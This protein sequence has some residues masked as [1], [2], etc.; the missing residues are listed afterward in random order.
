MSCCVTLFTCFWEF[1]EY[2]ALLKSSTNQF[3]LKQINQI[4]SFSLRMR[5]TYKLVCTSKLILIW[6][7]FLMTQTLRRTF[8]IHGLVH[9]NFLR[10]PR[11]ENRN[12]FL[13]SLM[14]RATSNLSKSSPKAFLSST[15][16]AIILLFTTVATDGHWIEAGREFRRVGS[17]PSKAASEA[18]ESWDISFTCNCQSQSPT[19]NAKVQFSQALSKALDWN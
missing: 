7:Y 9:C 19:Q 16:L 6:S 11:L 4:H 12:H 2:S 3:P 14:K 18:K 15:C 10:I 5:I 8:G 1:S 13:N 17:F